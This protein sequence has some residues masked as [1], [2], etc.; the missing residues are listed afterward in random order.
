[1][2]R[3]SL[4]A[5]ASAAALLL[6]ATACGVKAET[7]TNSSAQAS[8]SALSGEITFQ[9]WSLKGD[10]FS[11]YFEKLVKDFESSH[12]GTKINWIDQPGEG[13]EQKVLQQAN[14]SSLPDVVNLPPEFA[15]QLAKAQR[16]LDLKS[17]D[18]KLE[19]TYVTGGL[20]AYSFDGVEGVYGYPW[21][22][23]TDMNYF[24]T[25]ALAQAGVAEPKS[26]D[27]MVAAAKTMATKTNGRMPLIS[28]MP[29]L[30]DFSSAGAPIMKDG[31]FA[32]NSP[33][34]TAVLQQYVEL[35]QA[36]AMPAEVLKDNYL[37]NSAL[38][39]QGKVGWATGTAS[40][41]TDLKKEAPGLVPDTKVTAR[42]GTP[43]LFVQGISV[44]K[45]SKSPQLALAFAQHVV[46]NTNQVEF[47]KLAQGFMPGTKEATANPEQFTGAIDDKLMVEAVKI[48]AS[49]MDK[50]EMPQPPQFSN[51]MKTYLGQQMALALRGDITAQQALDKSVD[52]CNKKLA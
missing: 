48:A 19:E 15:Y 43:P 28:T 44:A 41:I 16:L 20:K 52:Y 17:V 46:D 36:K 10:K 29:A 11:P 22:L 50:A 8:A 38:Y 24:N 42:F 12:P 3:R 6:G 35:Y 21:Y 2:R 37:G 7:S 1:M 23:G 30:Q 45:E 26:W 47:V 51:D 49:Q 34:A 33:E 9:S 18:P 31:K 13:Y 5:S 25:K 14:S 40:M 4:L 39:K 32:F 27:E